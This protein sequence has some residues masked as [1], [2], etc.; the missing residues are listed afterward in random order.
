[1]VPIPPPQEAAGDA[2]KLAVLTDHHQ[3]RLIILRYQSQSNPHQQQNQT[4]IDWTPI[5][6]ESV[7]LLD[8]MGRPAAESGLNVE[9]E[10]GPGAS[11]LFSHTHAGIL[12]VAPL[13]GSTSNKM[14]TNID[15]CST[16]L[17][18]AFGVR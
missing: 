11:F 9:V 10:Q 2:Q 4:Q 12:K 16:D 1:M 3:P 17:S 13:L 6:T 14:K 15:E 5:K 18:R 8:E 7:L